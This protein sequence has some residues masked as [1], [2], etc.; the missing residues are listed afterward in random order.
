LI[1]TAVRFLHHFGIVLT[2]YLIGVIAISL[3]IKTTYQASCVHSGSAILVV[4][5]DFPTEE[6]I[7]FVELLRSDPSIIP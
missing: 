2:E 1:G 4:I 7:Y 5:N 3:T 6:M